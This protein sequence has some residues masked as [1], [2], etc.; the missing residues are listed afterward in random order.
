MKR[1]VLLIWLLAAAP[2]LGADPTIVG[3]VGP[4]PLKSVSWVSLEGLA[5]GCTATFFPSEQL[6][7]GPPHLQPGH[8]IFWSDK[9][10]KFS[11]SAV[12]VDWEARTLTPLTY[13][14]TVGTSPDPDPGPDPDPDPEPD[15]QPGRRWQIMFF[16]ESGDLDDLPRGQ[17]ELLS[18]LSLREELAAAGHY[19]LG[20]SDKD[21]CS[22]GTCPVK[23]RPFWSAVTGDPMP[24]V[25]LA[26]IGGGSVKDYPLPADKAGLFKLLENP[27]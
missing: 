22:T 6:T 17:V 13:T 12:V 4:V 15:P 10:G 8:G 24:R 23:L 3:P 11:I 5:A 1:F 18:S 14:I 7:V 19:V 21:A 2:A 26:P 16:Q 9:V 27:Q 20:V 25:A